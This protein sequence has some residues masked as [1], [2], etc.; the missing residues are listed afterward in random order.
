MRGREARGREGG[1]ARGGDSKWKVESGKVS[2]DNTGEGLGN[3]GDAL[4]FHGGLGGRGAEGLEEDFGGGC[5]GARG[6]VGDEGF[7]EGVL[8]GEDGG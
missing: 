1:R 4:G 2:G 5:G 8:A 7:G 3:G 6:D